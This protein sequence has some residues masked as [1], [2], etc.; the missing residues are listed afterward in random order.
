MKLL[1]GIKQN[2]YVADVK[3]SDYAKV[4]A[5]IGLGSGLSQS[6]FLSK[7]VKSIIDSCEKSISPMSKV[8]KGGLVSASILAS[9]SVAAIA[10]LVGAIL[11]HTFKQFIDGFSKNKSK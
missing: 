4:G 5:F 7:N 1:T 8:R 6:Y 2:S 10:T 3:S 9:C 11:G